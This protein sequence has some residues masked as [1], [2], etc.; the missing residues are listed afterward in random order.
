M[1][2]Y[3]FCDRHQLVVEIVF[4][5]CQVTIKTNLKLFLK[6]DVLIK[7]PTQVKGQKTKR[8]GSLV[9]VHIIFELTYNSYNYFFLR[10][11]NLYMT[12]LNVKNP[13]CVFTC[14]F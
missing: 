5:I 2:C 11:D 4:I 12:Y 7:N 6:K 10:L 13:N 9:K 14:I 8:L 3:V 1:I